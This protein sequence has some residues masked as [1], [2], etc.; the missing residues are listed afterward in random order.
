MSDNNLIISI[1]EAREILG[2]DAQ[3][4][5]DEEIT[6]VISTLDILA[7]DALELA[8]LQLRRKKDAKD[9]ANLIYDIYQDKK[10]AG[11]D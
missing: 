9:L 7:K 11:K 2:S 8:K 5:S 1:E 4:M 3:G 6:Q 10:K